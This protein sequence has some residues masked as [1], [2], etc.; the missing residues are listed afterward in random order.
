MRLR[1]TC[2]GTMPLLMHNVQLASPRNAYAQKLKQL[3]AKTRKTEEDLDEIARVEFE[4]GLY[5]DEEAGPYMPSYNLFRSF[6]SGA[7]LTRAG[8]KV[9]RGLAMAEPILPLIYDGPRTR[10][11]LWKN[12]DFVDIRSASVQRSRVDRC[13]PI[14]KK[15]SIE[16]DVLLDTSILELDEFTRIARQAGAYEGLGDFRAQ[17]GRF[18]VTMTK[19]PDDYT[20]LG[21]FDEEE[22]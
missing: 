6:V 3:N 7:K 22:E 20:D 11:G 5:F 17:F 18:S 15:W 16:A 14:F 8:K 2:T 1:I 12:D 21:D 19:L 10:E 9:E 4:G 13:R